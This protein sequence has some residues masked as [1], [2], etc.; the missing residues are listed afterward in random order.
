[1]YVR[2]SL[3]FTSDRNASC[4]F[5]GD[6]CLSEFGNLKLDTGYINTH[7]DLGINAPREDRFFLRNMYHCAPLKTD[8]FSSV[9]NYVDP[10]NNDASALSRLFYGRVSISKPY[11][12]F[13]Y[14][15]PTNNSRGNLATGTSFASPYPD[16]VVGSVFTP[17]FKLSLHLRG[18]GT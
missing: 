13:T 3:H 2:P 8:G 16:Y 4:P 11:A 18:T 15:F 12:N 7:E 10:D 14:Q 6:I 1:M 9:Y 17:P 5:T